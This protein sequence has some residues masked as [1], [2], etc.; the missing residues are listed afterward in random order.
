MNHPLGCV[1]YVV[2]ADDS[3]LCKN[4]IDATYSTTLPR[5]QSVYHCFHTSVA[6]PNDFAQVCYNCL[7][8]SRGFSYSRLYSC[9]CCMG[10]A[11]LQR[12][13]HDDNARPSRSLQ[14][15]ARYSTSPVRDLHRIQPTR[16]GCC[17][18]TPAVHRTHPYLELNVLLLELEAQAKA[19]HA[20][21]HHL[22]L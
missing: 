11:S 10:V 6:L 14:P 5:L 18:T 21:V 12:N 19:Y 15:S 20:L 22:S 1:L 16:P 7:S 4:I 2:T 17:C 3:Q 13:G 9:Q 8:S